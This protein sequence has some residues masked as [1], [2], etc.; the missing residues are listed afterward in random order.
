M[1]LKFVHKSVKTTKK[2][3]YLVWIKTKDG[4]KLKSIPTYLSKGI[5]FLQQS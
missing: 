4:L 3:R 5:E 2:T 1:N